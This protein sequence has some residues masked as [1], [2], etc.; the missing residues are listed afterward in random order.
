MPAAGHVPSSTAPDRGREAVY[1]AEDMAFGGTDLDELVGLAGLVELA[2][3]L[4]VHDGWWPGPAV[5][6]RAGRSDA[7]S[8]SASVGGAGPEVVVRISAVQANRATLAHEL[9]HALAGPAQGHDGV[10]RRALLDVVGALTNLD[11][12]DRRR[13]VHVDALA[14]AYAHLGLP[15]ADRRWPPPPPW[16]A[17]AL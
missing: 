4:T 6:V 10:F 1:L 7:R 2:T 16:G 12:A 15:V 8:S 17:I 3:Q 9:A 11:P 5:Q 13:S 14:D